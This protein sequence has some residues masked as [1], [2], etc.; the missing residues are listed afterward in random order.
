[1]SADLARWAYCVARAGA[2]LPDGLPGVEPTHEVRRVEHGGLAALASAVPLA[3]FGEAALR[4]NLNDLNWLERVARCHE[5]VLEQAL[6]QA[7]IVPLRLCTIFADEPGLTGMLESQRAV[8]ERALDA[9][10]GTHEW[11]VKL[12]VDR[13]ALEAASRGA[14]GAPAAEAAGSGAAYLQRRRDERRTAEAA[15]R[16]AADLAEDVHQALAQRS[17]AARRNPPQN[18]ELSGHRGDMLLN[19]AYLVERGGSERLRGLV[20]QL[21]ERHRPLGAELLLAGPLPPYTFVPHPDSR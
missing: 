11:A 20:E 14:S 10:D 7:T 13:T 1:V 2:P 21:Q 18:R 12:L 6:D 5:W 9:L 19:G 4:R 16:L 3:E 8:L 17:L 15:G